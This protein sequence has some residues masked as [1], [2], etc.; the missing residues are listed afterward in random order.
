MYAPFAQSDESWR[1]WMSLVVRQ[2]GLDR[3]LR[4]IAE[5]KQQVWA[6]DNQIPVTEIRSMDDWMSVSL[7][8]QRFNML[9]AG[10]IRGTRDAARRSRNLRHDGLSRQPAHQR[11]RHPHGARRATSR[12]IKTRSRR[13]SEARLRRDRGRRRRSAAAITRVMATSALRRNTHRSRDVHVS[14]RCC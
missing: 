9:L 12:R 2:R 5:R 6:I 10:I 1:R 11:N 7:A 14:Q 4:P 13:R 3:A 8:R